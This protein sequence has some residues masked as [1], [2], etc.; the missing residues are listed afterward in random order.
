[1]TDFASIDSFPAPNSVNNKTA[2][3]VLGLITQ[4]SKLTVYSNWTPG[5]VDI[6]N[7]GRQEGEY[8]DIS[9]PT[10]KLELDNL[11]AS[12]GSAAK[13]AAM[14][15]LLLNDLVPNEMRAPLPESLRAAQEAAKQQ[16]I[17]YYLSQQ[18]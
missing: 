8:Y 2:G 7:D 5:T 13:V 14:K 18:S 6:A 10:G 9:T 12:S 15:A 11:Y 1:M 16:L 17:N 3:H 4:D